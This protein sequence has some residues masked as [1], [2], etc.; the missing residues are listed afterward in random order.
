[1]PK[2]A[3]HNNAQPSNTVDSKITSQPSAEGL[4]AAPAQKMATVLADRI[5]HDIASSG[6]V[7]GQVFG[8]EVALMERY[9]VSRATLREAVRQL[10]RHGV[11]TMRRGFG[12]GLTVQEP[13]QRAAVRALSTFLELTDVSLH[14]LFEAK[15]ILELR[16]VNLA[17]R[18]LNDE[19]IISMRD[20]IRQI[21]ETPLSEIEAEAKLHAR[22]RR[23]IATAAGNPALAVFLE[24]L[25]RITHKL[26]PEYSKMSRMTAEH[27]SERELRS[28]LVEALISGDARVAEQVTLEE[29][30]LAQQST[31]RTLKKFRRNAHDDKKLDATS[32]PHVAPWDAQDKL[33]HR[34]AAAIAL[35]ISESKLTQGSR[36]GS[37]PEFLERFGVSRAIFREAIRLLEG[38]GIVQMRRGY[39]GGLV[40]GH[41]DP[42]H[43]T[44]LVTT[45]LKH[46]ELKRTHFIELVRT[47]W[48]EAAPWAAQRATREQAQ[49]QLERAMSINP[50]DPGVAINQIRQQF[51][52]LP[53]LVENRAISLIGAVV[54]ELAQIYSFET[55]PV[56][57]VQ[58]FKQYQCDLFRAIAVGDEGIARRTLDRYFQAMATHYES[59]RQ[60]IA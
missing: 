27:R 14:E 19:H 8:N 42:R 60:D 13:A 7:V 32:A 21:N 29:L 49:I 55:P 39:G 4:N 3:D 22:I 12:G 48:I 38:Y 45:Y 37:E 53:S 50:C 31:E 35:E 46:A 16:A 51:S 43:T 5:Q 20:D 18:R 15:S 44:S 10:E 40:V 26:L 36:V 2:K 47:I 58:E 54:H 24:G 6:W 11:A 59:T 30:T 25:N 57:I 34:L 56:K 28:R 23:T 1:M 41:P 52:E 17:C 33:P 9:E